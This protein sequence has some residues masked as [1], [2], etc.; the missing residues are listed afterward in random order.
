MNASKRSGRWVGALALSLLLTL[1]CP[2]RPSAGD[3]PPARRGGIRQVVLDGLRRLT[4]TS[5]PASQPAETTTKPDVSK[6]KTLA[7]CRGLF[8]KGQ[9][10]TA[11]EAYRKFTDNQPDEMR[12]S[13]AIG[14]SG[15][16]AME[17]KYTEAI[18]ALKPVAKAADRDAAWH[19][20]MAEALSNVGSY[21]EALKHAERANELR[22]AW[23]PAILA[24]GQLLEVHGRSD[25]AVNV[26][27]SMEKTVETNEYKRDARSLVALGKILDRYSIMTGRKASAQ[28]DNIYNN[29]LR[30]AYQDVDKKYWPAYVAAGMFALSK[31][32]ARY[33]AADFKAAAEI[34]K[35]IPE[36]HVGIGVLQLGR[37]GFE[38]CLSEA[39][40]ALKI[41]PRLPDGH[42]L[43]AVCYM[44][45]RK[46]E[47]A[48]P[49][50]TK[51]LEP[52]PNNIEA[53]SL[54]AAAYVCMYEPEKAQPYI[55][56]VEKINPRCAEMH[57]IIG[58]WLSAGRQFEEAER[59]FLKAIE[60][61]PKLSEPVTSLGLLYMQTGQEDKA[62]E[63][64]QKAHEL[65]DYRADVV[66]YLSLLGK[67]EKFLVKE[68][69]HFI[70]KVDGK[71][72]AVLLDQVS[73][74]MESIY[75]EVCTDYGYEP[76]FKT[77]IEIFPTQTQFSTRLSG[78]GWIPTVGA[79]TG[80]VIV[81]AAPAPEEQRTPLG[82]HNWAVVLRHE[83]THVVTL[84]GTA[85][86]IPHWFTEACAVWQQPDK[87]AYKHIST[88]VGATR[89]DK[90]MPIKD[91]DWGFIRPRRPDQRHLAYAQSEWALTYIVT[92]KGY[93]VVPKMLKGFRDGLTQ[94]EVFEKI[95]GVKE[96]EFD[97]GFK[98]WAK[99]Q[100]KQWGFNPDPPPKL[101]DAA[102]NASEHP[103]DANAHADHAV[104]LYYARK[105]PEAL[106]AAEKAIEIDPN[107]TRALGVK[108]YTLMVDKKYEQAIDA[109]NKLEQVD[110]ES[111]IAPRVLADCYLKMKGETSALRA[112]AINALELLQQRR[113]MEQYSYDQLCK[114]YTNLGMS[115]RAL[116]NLIHLHRHTMKASKYAKQAAEIYRTKRQYDNALSYYRQVLHINPYDA[117]VYETIAAI[118][119][120]TKRYDQAI[121]A[122]RDLTLL[123][124][125]SANAWTKLAMVRCNVGRTRK[126]R[127]L[128]QQARQDAT[129]ALSLDP[130]GQAKE[131]LAVIEEALKDL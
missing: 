122:A 25:E 107:H 104:A 64:L 109:A 59:Y 13:A 120:R 101:A 87:R 11:T 84:S 92:T 2:P 98:A 46:H 5:R 26:Y 50:I 22:P 78:R 49:F 15:A 112:K 34:N 116:R 114:I 85:N 30:A 20:A 14:L 77:L 48:I 53:L 95:V 79:C 28:G 130:D 83:F 117:S 54:M 12:I 118:Q 105:R 66:N 16:L 125:E 42:L 72:D 73:D 82:T 61:A 75:D 128:L 131:V 51:A 88:L 115:D 44:R 71:H 90:L 41:N 86:R 127:D 60:L 91:L 113:P 68:T 93:D 21:Q 69:D 43:K 8:D 106:A 39:D 3:E 45:W 99:T 111:V 6:I 100:V 24:R 102:K 121:S 89:T 23:A 80:R 47:K 31:H 29:Y 40:K 76:P 63:V 58:G 37:M 124:P 52:N 57:N 103:K 70:V 7:E 126:D 97:K 96:S 32:R 123:Q 4:T 10:A 119:L 110:H 36:V 27:K 1:A 67:L 62:K 38:Q 17:G 19:L 56:R 74:Y 108:A 55:Q 129:K 94:A 35:R 81:L 33:A 18:D 65:D 9:Y